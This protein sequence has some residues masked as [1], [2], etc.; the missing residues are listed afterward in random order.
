MDYEDIDYYEGY[1]IRDIDNNWLNG[2]M[3]YEETNSDSNSD[4]D[5]YNY[6]NNT[7]NWSTLIRDKINRQIDSY[8][9]S[10][11]EKINKKLEFLENIERSI[12]IVFRKKY[13]SVQEKVCFIIYAIN[14]KNN[15]LLKDFK[16][17]LQK[18]ID[19]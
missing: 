1:N 19:R 12:T 15:F 6:N 10:F 3:D 5:D 4:T 9:N 16:G 14:F 11:L 8:N 2:N 7:N 17:I 18:D 13:K